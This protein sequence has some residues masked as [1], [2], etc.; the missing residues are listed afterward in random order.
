[1]TYSPSLDIHCFGPPTVRVSGREA[2]P[3]V[4]WRK[5]LALLVYL[6]LSPNRTRSREHLLGLLWPDKEQTKARH[7]LNEAI[8]RL[9]AG[10]GSDRIV[11]RGDA[12]TLDGQGLTVDALE[13]DP[14]AEEF[15]DGLVIPDAP[16]FEDWLSVERARFR[17]RS[18]ATLLARGE[19]ALAA[20]DF[21]TAREVG[22]RILALEPTSE[23]AARLEMRALALAGDVAGALRVHRDFARRLAD[24]LGEQP[25]RELHALAERIRSDRWRVAAT[26][27]DA[28]RPAP[29][30]GRERAHADAFA[31]VTRAIAAGPRVLVITGL[32]GMGRSRLLAECAA[33]WQLEGGIAVLARPLDGDREAPWSTLRE[34]MR[35]GLLDAPGLAATDPA[36]LRMLAGVV[37]QLTGR[38]TPLAGMGRA[39]LAGALRDLLVA[40]ADEAPVGLFLDDAHLADDDT[41]AALRAALVRAGAL[42]VLLA[43]GL[44][45]GVPPPA[46]LQLLL[47]EIGRVVPGGGVHLGPLREREVRELVTALAPWCDNDQQRDRLARRIAFETGGDPLFA[48]TL[49]DGLAEVASLRDE[50]L[51]WPPPNITL[52]APVP[53]DV[54]HLVRLVVTARL[55]ELDE[56]ARRVL[57]A[58][59]VGARDVDPDIVAALLESG[60][61]KVDGALATLERARFVTFDG[62]RYGLA[63]RLIADVVLAELVTPGQR[64]RLTER[65]LELL[66]SGIAGSRRGG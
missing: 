51:V 15:L 2:P 45:E 52:E 12:V 44:L 55:A 26:G 19:D 40:V 56:F 8:R 32:T 63:A 54:P 18:I 3:D 14:P 42:P 58:A 41:L 1:M 5:H 34:L 23:R 22:R 20:L 28:H 48:V 35:S 4:V 24:E 11:S 60:R 61:N 53:F 17:E 66:G 30:V 16:G 29:L 31:E 25:G 43:I 50:A 46:P 36:A 13:P 64:K 27:Q 10:L 39:D 38:V 6:A 62:A 65:H 57:V 37:P 59:A 47:G 33:R 7:S 9:R 21:Q 49:L